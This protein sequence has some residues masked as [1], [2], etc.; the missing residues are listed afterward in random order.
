[1]NYTVLGNV[2]NLAAR[3]DGLNKEYD[4]QILV[5]ESVYQRI[6]HRFHCRFVD[7]VIAKGMAAETRI[8]ELLEERSDEATDHDGLAPAFAR[9]AA[10]LRPIPTQRSPL[11]ASRA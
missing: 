3:L 2:V 1:M 11:Q 5:S 6:R 10:R 4:T 7:T 8:Y 9:R